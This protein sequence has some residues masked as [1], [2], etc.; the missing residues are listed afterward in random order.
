MVSGALQGLCHQQRVGTVL[1]VTGVVLDVAAKQELVN[2]ID[3]TV[4]AKDEAR[5]LQ[6]TPNKTLVHRCSIFSSTSSI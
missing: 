3:L 6:V 4:G 5:G 2:L 1:Q